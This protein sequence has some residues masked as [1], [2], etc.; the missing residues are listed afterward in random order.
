MANIKSFPNNQDVYTGAEYV[1]KWLHGRTSGVFG[2][3]G[4]AAVTAVVGRMAV[5][6]SDGYGWIA[7]DRGDGVSWWIDTEKQTGSKLVL[8]VAMADSTL[9]RIDRVVVTWQTTNYVALP[10]VTILK[11][12]PASLPKP[13]TLTNNSSQRQISLAQIK[14]P[15][16]ATAIT[17]SMITDERMNKDVCGIVTEGIQIPTDMAQLQFTELLELIEKNLKQILAGQIADGAITTPKIAKGAVTEEKLS[18]GLIDK[19]GGIK[20]VW[21]N[22]SPTSQFTDQSISLPLSDADFIIIRARIAASKTVEKT[23][24]LAQDATTIMQIGNTSVISDL[25]LSVNRSATVSKSAI[26]FTSATLRYTDNT[27]VNPYNQGLIPYQIYAVNGGV[28]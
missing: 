19:L 26:N 20:K 25:S 5:N 12:A 13:P 15:A 8:D 2:A 14:I 18:K 3:N 17:P 23:F 16:G 10:T 9:A 21:E 28:L 4:N 24:L 7:N 1:M 27:A 22:A 6:V 11:G